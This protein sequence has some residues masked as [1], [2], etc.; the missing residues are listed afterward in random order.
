M[1]VD[2][3]GKF[4]SSSREV[5]IITNLCVYWDEIFLVEDDAPPPAESVEGSEP[6]EPASKRGIGM[7]GS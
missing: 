2:L 1:A 5:R 4:L 6:P 7:W 3:S